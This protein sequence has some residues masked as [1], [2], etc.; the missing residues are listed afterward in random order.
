MRSS[1]WRARP[2]AAGGASAERQYTDDRDRKNCA[3]GRHEDPG[4]Q[5]YEANCGSDLCA[6][7]VASSCG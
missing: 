1:D 4:R 2:D 6:K 3:A 5:V 7:A